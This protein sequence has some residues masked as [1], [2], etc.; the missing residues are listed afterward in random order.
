MGNRS[1]KIRPDN[2]KSYAQNVDAHTLIAQLKAVS[3]NPDALKGAKEAQRHEI[4]R[5]SRATA[6]SLDTP[7]ETM[8]RLCYAVRPHQAIGDQH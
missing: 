5:L 4:R 1:T 8:M 6:Q 2:R 7:Y 3:D